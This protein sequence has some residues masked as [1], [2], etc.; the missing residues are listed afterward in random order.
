MTYNPQRLR[1][2]N[3]ILRERLKG[4]AI[5]EYY[6]RRVATLRDLQNLYPDLETWDDDEVDRLEGLTLFGFL[7]PALCSA[8]GLMVSFIGQ[9]QE[10]K[11][12]QRRRGPRPV[13]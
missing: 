3:K 11:E 9:K 4:P 1:T 8:N 2:G 6:P 13:S 12:H 10:A 5:A 7:W